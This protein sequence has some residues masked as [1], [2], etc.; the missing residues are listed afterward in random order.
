MRDNQY[1]PVA[2][3]GAK[4]IKLALRLESGRYFVNA[5]TS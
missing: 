4:A 2:T 1:E 3:E 5:P